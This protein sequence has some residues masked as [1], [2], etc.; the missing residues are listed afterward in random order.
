MLYGAMFLAVSLDRRRKAQI[1]SL[2]APVTA[3]LE[4]MS[5]NRHMRP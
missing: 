2:G 5:A 3:A 4:L 1:G